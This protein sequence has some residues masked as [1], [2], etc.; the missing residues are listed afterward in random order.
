[1][2]ELTRLQA[3]KGRLEKRNYSVRLFESAAEARKALLDTLKEAKTVGIG[4]S[5]TIQSLE[6]VE[7][8]RENGTDVLWHWLS[9]E[10][11]RDARRE[12]MNAEVYLA[13]A[14]ALTMDGRLLF[15][16]GT[17]NRVGAILYG[18]Q[19]VILVVGKNKLA[20][21]LDA[22]FARIRECACPPN[23]KRLG[24]QTPCALTGKCTD[25]SSPQ[26]MC[27]AFL[28]LE[29]RPGAHPME[30]WLV[31]EDLGF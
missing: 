21:D 20:A 22:G 15:I 17:G 11:G 9:Q 5:A 25:C 7:T 2:S 29:R 23:A 31:D 14:N 26:R 30:V 13:S 24:L 6:I 10:V 27:N 4:G 28:T 12:A 19:R 18:P 16:D 8:L 3:V 1:M